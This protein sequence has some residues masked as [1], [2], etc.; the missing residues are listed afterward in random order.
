MPNHFH[1]LLRT[2]EASAAV[3][4]PGRIYRLETQPSSSIQPLPADA[5]PHP[6]KGTV[7][8]SLNA[9]IQNFKSISTRK[10]NQ[11]LDTPGNKIWQR[12]YYEHIIRNESELNAIRKYILGN[13]LRWQL[14]QENPARRKSDE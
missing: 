7:A 11:A 5:S 6:P 9:I 8:G 2:G 10:I 1:A 12:D 4:F 3:K 14:D 13:P